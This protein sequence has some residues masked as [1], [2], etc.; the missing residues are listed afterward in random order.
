MEAGLLLGYEQARDA[1]R[2]DALNVVVLASDGVAN[3]GVTDPT[4]LTD[5]ITQAGEEGIH[6]VTVGYG[7]GNYND[8]LMEQLADQGDGFYAYVDTFEEAERLFVEDLTPT[9]TVAAGDAKAQV[10]FDPAVVESYRLDRLREPRCST[11]RRSA[12]TPSTPASSARGHAVTA[13][14]EVRLADHDAVTPLA[15]APP[16]AE[17]GE[18]R[19]RWTTPD[20][21]VGRGVD[22]VHPDGHGAAERRVPAGRHRRPVRRAAKGNADVAERGTTLDD[23]AADVAPLVAAD[24]PGA[25][26]LAAAIHQAADID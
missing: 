12:T 24:V 9:L 1:F 14:Y 20:T 19:L 13:L 26:D 21:G 4:V 18:V 3:V 23:L 5:Q 11:T 15:A 10:V 6:L 8:H 2:P 17:L 25:A 7:M 22:H 16:A